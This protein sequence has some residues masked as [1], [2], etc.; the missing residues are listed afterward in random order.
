MCGMIF[1][2]YWIKIDFTSF[3]LNVVGIFK[4]TIY[5]TVMVDSAT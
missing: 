5:S 2:A 3:F 4:M 1:M